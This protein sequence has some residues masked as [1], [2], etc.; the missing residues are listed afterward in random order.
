M[1]APAPAPPQ[2]N[3]VIIPMTMTGDVAA[4][5][6]EIM[7]RFAVMDSICEHLRYDPSFMDP[8]HSGDTF[9]NVDALLDALEVDFRNFRVHYRRTMPDEL[10]PLVALLRPKPASLRTQIAERRED[11]REASSLAWEQ[12]WYDMVNAD[13]DEEDEE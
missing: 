4:D 13:S 2:R 11:I 12:F 9:D 3:N 8:G 7:V 10:R 6:E 5:L 1:A